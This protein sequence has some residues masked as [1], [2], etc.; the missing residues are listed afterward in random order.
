LRLFLSLC[1]FAAAALAQTTED[2]YRVYTGHPRLFLRPQRL[3]LLQRERPRQSL[4]WRQFEMLV[5]GKVTFPEPGFALALYY[6]VS[7]DAEVGKQ[8]VAWALRPAADIQQTAL[9][10]DW[11]Q[12]LLTPDQ[13]VELSAKLRKA[14][15]TKA[16][17]SLSARRDRILAA[18]AL[19]ADS[20][21]E[22]PVLRES[23]EGWWRGR[24]APALERGT[25]LKLDDMYALYEILHAVRDNLSI[26]L[27][28]SAT[29]WF[30][31]AAEYEVAANYPAPFVAA[32]NEYRVPVW[33]GEGQPDLT[34][35]SLAR[36]AGLS[37]VAYDSNAVE[38]SYLQG[39]LIQDRFLMRTPFGIPYEF[40]WAN[41]YQPGLSFHHLP[42]DFHD[43]QSGTLFLRSSWDEDALWF[44][45]VDGE[46][47]WF[48]DGRIVV[49]SGS[50]GKTT[51]SLGMVAV[52]K[53]SG[54]GRLETEGEVL[55]VIGLRP[56]TS[57]DVEVDD[58]EMR[59]LETDAAGTMEIRVSLPRKFGVRFREAAK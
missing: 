51:R 25:R 54:P 15:A 5:T 24:F 13:N 43:P 8:A 56:R 19:D 12:D 39:W 38:S 17:D 16:S 33:P 27:R 40:L 1:L 50:G 4:R 23:V 42:P 53:A 58:E 20:H 46:A 59:E 18:I 47:Q 22:E 45:L 26:D 48:E 6:A 14:I 32:E 36:A 30:K 29:D 52:A 34:R 21:P 35:A 57:Y 55:F 3:R 2:E 28:Q 41:P 9:V 44:G 31:R 10:Y 11:C 7:R 49:L 37:T